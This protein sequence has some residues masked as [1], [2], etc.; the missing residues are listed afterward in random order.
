[1]K[2]VAQGDCVAALTFELN[3]YLS[4]DHLASKSMKALTDKIN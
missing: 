1:M 3:I 4:C 2:V